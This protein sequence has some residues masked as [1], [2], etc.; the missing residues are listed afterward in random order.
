MA[1]DKITTAMITDDAVTAAKIPAGAIGTTEIAEGALSTHALQ[2]TTSHSLTGTY[3]DNKMYTSDAYTLSGDTTVNSNLILSSVKGDD[4]DI[5]LT[6]DSTTRTLTGTGVLS[7][8]SI[9]GKA[10]QTL[11]GM[12]GTLGSVITGSPALILSNATKFPVGHIIQVKHTHK[13]DTWITY[14]ASQQNGIYVPELN[15]DITPSSTL[16]KILV[17][18]QLNACTEHHGNGMQMWVDINLAKVTNY[19]G[20]ASGSR[21]RVI[22]GAYEWGEAQ[23]DVEGQTVQMM[24]SFVDT[25]ASIATLNYAVVL[26][27]KNNN[28]W[29]YVNRLETDSDNADWPRGASSIIAM[30]IQG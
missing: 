10:I 19:A 24:G 6:T 26:W 5:T 11:T 30:E 8:G 9:S 4:S 15:V 3:T 1:L 23:S 27:V 13:L 22:T 12:T 29:F 7:G 28:T 20:A 25:P 2:N 21:G 14:Q 17:M 18:V 16:S